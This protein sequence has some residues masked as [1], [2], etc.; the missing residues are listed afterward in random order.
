MQNKLFIRNLS[1]KTEDAELSELF[2]SF[3]RVVSAKV[4][5]DRETGRGRGFGFVEMSSGE[6]ASDAMAALNSS[7]FG[8]RPIY[9]AISEPR[10]SRP[11]E[12][13]W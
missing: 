12:R 6:G 13:N 2:S 1:Y 10:A 9:V 8:G 5:V 3:G 11:N 4:A 7:Q